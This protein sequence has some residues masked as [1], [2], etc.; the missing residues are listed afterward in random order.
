MERFQLD[1][2]GERLSFRS[3]SDPQRIEDAKA[4]VEEQF[5][6]LKAHGGQYSRDKLLTLLIL[7]VADDL[8][9]LQQQLDERDKRVL[10]LLKRI[11][12]VV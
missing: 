1:V 7:G 3:Q 8:L 2:L 5:E 10:T 6:R 4:F 9:Q 12:D 11:E